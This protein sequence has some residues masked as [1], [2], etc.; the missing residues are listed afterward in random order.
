MTMSIPSRI[1]I[2]GCTGFVG[3][4][5]VEQCRIRYP[6]AELFGLSGHS[7]FHTAK[8]GMS[9]VKLLV[10]DITQPESI[11]KVVARSQPDLIIHL[12]A[13]SSVSAS[14]KDPLGTLKVNAGG[15]IHLLEALRS[16]QL[17][18]RVVLIGSGEQYGMVRPEDNPIR[19]ECPFRPANPYAVSKAVQDL[20]GYQYFVAYGL[21]ILRAR[22]FNH[23]GPRQSSTFVVANFARQ[24]ALI[25]AEKA[26]P[27]LSVGNLQARRDF[28]P[29]EDVVAAYLA[30]AEQGQPGEAYN[31]GSGQA[32]SIRAILVLLLTFTGTAIQL[33]ED[34]ARLRP[35]DVPL[36]EANT[37]RL[38]ADT[39]WEPAVQFEFALQRTL[40][41]WRTV[42]TSDSYTRK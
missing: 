40:D 11:R 31:I 3:G 16:E 35:V 25:E 5:L 1:L 10:A 6:Q 12:A 13:Q 33:R 36:L 20:Y 7:T 17:T 22:P 34:P 21:P 37:S 26:E 14:W 8:P 4:Y 39:N 38:R 15:T 19:E 29:V 28:L 32:R 9:G 23:F 30:V 2:T 42:V 18:P 27:V 24:I 41:Y